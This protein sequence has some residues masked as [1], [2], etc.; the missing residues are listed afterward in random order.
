MVTK[1]VSTE[2]SI[3]PAPPFQKL[4]GCGNHFVVIDDRQRV[5]TDWRLRTPHLLDRSFGVAAD[6][7]L[8]LRSSSTT[9]FEVEMYNPDGSPMGMC[10]NG[11]R[12]VV[13]ALFSRGILQH[14]S[15]ER[16][17]ISFT[18]EG[19]L[20]NCVAADDG[21]YTYVNMGRPSFT[22]ESVPHGGSGAA[23]EIPIVVANESLTITALSMGNPH[24]V[25]FCDDPDA[26]DL[27]KLG[28]KLENHEFFP[29]R[30]NVHFV[31]I[32][33]KSRLSMRSW[34]RGVGATLACGTGACASLV[35]ASWLGRCER[36]AE[37][38]V[39]GGLLS[40]EWREDDHVVL[41][42]PAFEVFNGEFS[43]YL[44]SRSCQSLR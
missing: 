25:I 42:G 17:H 12:C 15:G 26:V 22:P 21:T 2:P 36:N 14:L 7:L 1:R 6:G 28:P 23:K 43:R 3:P 39:P 16:R 19:R 8:V 32:V 44:W 27:Q 13:R 33:S 20:I 34:E 5:V 18:V 29:N 9:D 38:E 4:E 35:A 10:G 30:T 11:I 37:V 41:G 31:K 40:V 24:C